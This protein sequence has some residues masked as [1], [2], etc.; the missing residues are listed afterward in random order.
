MQDVC[1]IC[2]DEL[3]E[4]IHRLGGCDH[5]FHSGCIIAWMRRGNLSCPTCRGDLHDG[6]HSSLVGA[7]GMTV[8]ERSSYLRRLSRRSS[9]PVE[10]K[11]LV[12]RIRKAETNARQKARECREYDRAHAEVLKNKR[13]KRQ[14]KWKAEQLAYKLK[15]LL[16]VFHSSA[17]PL[18]PLAV[19]RN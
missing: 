10:L 8:W 4:D 13:M 3:S 18:P 17:Y 1:P 16:G 15:R 11:R 12:E 9:A 19:V 6:T 5:A 7:I 2:H 14:K